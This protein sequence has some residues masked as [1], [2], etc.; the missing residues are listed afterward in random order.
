MKKLFFIFAFLCATS[1]YAQSEHYLGLNFGN[2]L[3]PTY[4]F[5]HNRWFANG[6]VGWLTG[7]KGGY[8]SING[9]YNIWPTIGKWIN[10]EKSIPVY[11]MN[12]GIGFFAQDYRHPTSK[13][14]QWAN[15]LQYLGTLGYF[16][17]IEERYQ[18]ATNWQISF[19][20]RSPVYF[21]ESWA[22]YSNF[23]YLLLTTC[24]FSIQ[25]KI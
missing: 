22:K 23:G 24:Q 8:V 15:N 25:Y 10:R 3:G 7:F 20:L 2:V 9:T 11:Q 4:T 16:V 12:V 18:L 21:E 1:T 14:Q 17:I 6:T 13:Q 19:S 5:Q